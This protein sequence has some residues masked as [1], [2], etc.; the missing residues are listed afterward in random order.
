MLKSKPNNWSTNKITSYA[1]I[2]VRC[3]HISWTLSSS[4]CRALE[5]PLPRS[6]GGER[7]M[8][9]TSATAFKSQIQRLTPFFPSLRPLQRAR[10]RYTSVFPRTSTAHSI[11]FYDSHS[12]I[13]V[14]ACTRTLVAFAFH[15]DQISSHKA[16]EPKLQPEVKQDM[17][18]RSRE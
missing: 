8:R 12:G 16:Q 4:I 18:A 10:C 7:E 6:T 15:S 13:V 2:I 3:S 5:M 11:S 9:I 14:I 17:K 1:T